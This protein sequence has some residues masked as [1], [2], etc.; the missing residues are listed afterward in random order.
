M[1]ALLPAVD[2]EPALQSVHA[3]LPASGAKLPAGQLVHEALPEAGE[4][5]AGQGVQVPAPAAE[6]LP[7]A[8][9]A[10]LARPSEA[11]PA[12]QAWQVHARGWLPAAQLLGHGVVVG[13][14]VVVGCGVV[15]GGGGAGPPASQGLLSIAPWWMPTGTTTKQEAKSAERAPQV[16]LTSG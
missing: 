15:L 5:P 8:H 4:L 6:K 13:A 14:G 1:Q 7:A 2:E 16:P 11:V 12:A 3:E 9:A 10:Q